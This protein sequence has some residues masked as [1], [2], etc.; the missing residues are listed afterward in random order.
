M[1][2]FAIVDSTWKRVYNS[3]ELRLAE[4]REDRHEGAMKAKAKKA[5]LLG[6]Y[7][8][9]RLL[10]GLSQDVRA[11]F[12]RDLESLN[13]FGLQ[14]IGVKA[15]YRKVYVYADGEGGVTAEFMY[16]DKDGYHYSVSEAESP[17]LVMSP[18]EISKACSEVREDMEL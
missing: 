2:D 6:G 4:V 12:E 9:Y 7:G 17:S 16:V 15:D 11:F 13:L 1:N 3:F 14:K 18:Q 8:S 5:D 10:A